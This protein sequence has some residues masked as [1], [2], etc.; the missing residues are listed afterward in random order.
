MALIGQIR[1]NS[2]LLIAL[3][4][5]G[6][7]GFIVMDMFSGQQSIFG[8][9]QFIVGEVEGTK[10]DWNEFSRTEQI[11][12]QNSTDP[13]ST[14][15]ALWDFYVER[16]LLEEEAEVLGL[17]VGKDELLD[18]QFGADDR[19]SPIIRQRYRN[20]N[21]G[22][23]NRELLSQLQ[24]IITNDR[25][26]QLVSEGQLSPN[27][28]FQW[29]HQEKEIKKDRIQTKLITL[30]TKSLYTPSWMAEEIQKEQ[31][32]KVDIQY[33]QIPFD[34]VDNSQIE[35]TDSD[36]KEYYNK[37]INKYIVKEEKRKI[38]YVVFDVLPTAKDSAKLKKSFNDLIEEFSK[39]EDDSTFIVANQGIYN[40]VYTKQSELSPLIADT[41]F[42]LSSGDIYG[43]YIEGGAYKAVK[44]IDRKVIP[45]SV[46]SRH[47]LARVETQ[48][49][50]AAAQKRIDSLKTLIED[51]VQPFDSLAIKFSDDGGSGAKGG[52]LGYAAP[53]QMV[54]PFNNYLFYDGEVGELGVVYSQFGIHLIEI[55]DKK[56]VTNE[57]GVKVAYI[58]QPIVPS[59]VTQ[60]SLYNYVSDF[61]VEHRTLEDLSAAI[62]ENPSL[63]LEESAQLGK[64]DYAVANLGSGQSSRDII[65]YAF[66]ND[67]YEGYVS[68]DIFIYRNPVEFY[69]EKY[70]IAGLKSIQPAG[71]PTLENIKSEIEANVINKKKSEYLKSQISTTNLFELA[72]AYSTEVDTAKN[73]AFSSGFVQGLGVEPDVVATAF[74]LELN[75]VS[76]PIAG[77]SGVFV[78]KVIN[79]P[80]SS[81]TPV[82]IPQLRK[83]ANVGIVN[84]V[85][86]GLLGAMKE[87]AT[88]KDYRSRFY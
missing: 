13:F 88:I 61:V 5:L 10:I 81:P 49:Q 52:D 14:R 75:T 6:L 28:R 70:I 86:S 68:P 40:P 20:Q 66:D 59:Q 41:V 71:K 53:G 4:A 19:L 12:Y 79:K 26:G 2:W 8:S 30:V 65:K 33:V 38:E 32:Q 21:T 50:L 3:I 29:A 63:Q 69:D 44:L 43:P 54:A 72:S 73:V 48:E 62:A 51:G 23:V 17:R 39:T 82:N 60:D 57:E 64:N 80:V 27:F 58:D 1:K 36:Y 46:D 34:E 7:G 45:D 87:N 47:I 42:A 85:R 84:Q 74:N 16:T 83:T 31:S 37:H 25:I 24:D 18:L 56:F 55:L 76:D 67:T 35:V 15:K 22:Q 78:I 77:N 11:I 9:S